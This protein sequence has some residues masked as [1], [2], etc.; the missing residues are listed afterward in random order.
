MVIALLRELYHCMRP[1][2]SL[3]INIKCK[4]ASPLLYVSYLVLTR[5]FGE[6]PILSL[7]EFAFYFNSLFINDRIPVTKYNNKADFI[8]RDCGSN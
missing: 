4:I 3:H 1:L 2:I 5:L 8:C 7:Y 6:I